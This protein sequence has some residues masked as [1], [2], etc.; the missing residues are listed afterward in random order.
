MRHIS[1]RRRH[2]SNWVYT[3]A[4]VCILLV[5]LCIISLIPGSSGSSSD[6]TDVTPSPE[7]SADTAG[8]ENAGP[9]SPDNSA[10]SSTGQGS[11]ATSPVE[12]YI[13][14]TINKEKFS[15]LMETY[16]TSSSAPSTQNLEEIRVQLQEL[17]LAREQLTAE[18]E[19]FRTLYETASEA[20]ASEKNDYLQKQ[21]ELQ[22]ESERLKKEL[23]E[24]ESQLSKYDSKSNA[25]DAERKKLSEE[26]KELQ[27]TEAQ[28]QHLLED[29]THAR[30]QLTAERRE[31]ESGIKSIKENPNL[32]SESK[33]TALLPLYAA[34]EQL[35]MREA[36][37]EHSEAEYKERSEALLAQKE[38]LST[39]LQNH[40]VERDKLDKLLAPHKQTQ[41]KL[42]NA[43]KS[44]EAQ[45]LPIAAELERIGTEESALGKEYQDKL[46]TLDAE[47]ERITQEEQTLKKQ[48][49]SLQTPPSG[50]TG[51]STN[52]TGSGQTNSEQ[53]IQDTSIQNTN[54]LAQRTLERILIILQDVSLS[55][56]SNTTSDI[57]LTDVADIIITTPEPNNQHQGVSR[58][59]LDSSEANSSGSH[60]DNN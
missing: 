4:A 16:Q 33:E 44:T 28:L 54:I 12:P 6:D 29:I 46:A 48:T 23:A 21:A 53:N 56:A 20:L 3:I 22:A 14:I 51:N 25:L 50:I 10:G 49:A 35:L 47:E 52:Q 9:N 19:E 2:T 26:E 39:R 32:S 57:L 7:L 40:E 5:T 58:T 11:N 34:L 41:Q 59:P 42:T 43:L 24:T 18:R 8:S 60:K 1:R 13:T 15:A 27:Q 30:E 37:L 38:N 55:E 36:Q 45:L 17:A 31:L